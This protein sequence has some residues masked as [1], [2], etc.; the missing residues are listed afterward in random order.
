MICFS[1]YELLGL[2]IILSIIA[3]YILNL[4]FKPPTIHQEKKYIN[5]IIEHDKKVL[6][7]ELYPP[8]NRSALPG[9]FG[10]E[11]RDGQDTFR[12][13]ANLTNKQ[14]GF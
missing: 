9:I 6:H 8:Y 3:W 11:T 2:I 7:D 12:L 4:K 5:P 14:T 13:V 10:I 1:K